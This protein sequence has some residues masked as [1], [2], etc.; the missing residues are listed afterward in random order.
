MTDIAANIEKIRE[1]IAKASKRVNRDPS[2]IKIVAATKDVP[3]DL[4]S[5]AIEAG[6][7]E[8]GENKVQEAGPKYE[9]LSSKYPNLTWHMIG[10]LQT[11]KVKKALEIFSII[12]SVDSLRLAEEIDRRAKEA[13]KKIDI[14]IEVNTSG[15]ITKFGAPIEAVRQ[16]VRLVSELQNVKV[17]G[18]MTVGL[19]TDDPEKARPSFRMIRDLKEDIDRQKIGDIEMKYLS[20]GMT[21]DFEVAIEE[22]SNLVRIGR[23]I[24]GIEHKH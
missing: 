4:I 12:H 15:E 16:L 7:T 22:G 17:K 24:F 2:E 21:D 14:L 5:R 9:A 6:I 19:L 1:R 3:A 18:L 23:A 10:H 13:G 11:N 8:I 20:M